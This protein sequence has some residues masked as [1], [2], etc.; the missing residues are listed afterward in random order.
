MNKIESW[1]PTRKGIIFR[2]LNRKH[3]EYTFNKQN[4]MATTRTTNI[5]LNR[6]RIIKAGFDVVG[7][8]V[9]GSCRFDNAKRRKKEFLKWKILHI[10][11][12]NRFFPSAT[13]CTFKRDMQHL[14]AFHLSFLF[15]WRWFLIILMTMKSWR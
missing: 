4:A 2:A 14:F 1:R 11:C 7:N 9:N 15:W 3:N 6:M 13:L 12:L 5:V 10:F 8:N